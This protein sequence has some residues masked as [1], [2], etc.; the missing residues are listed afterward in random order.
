[1][2]LPAAMAA[3]TAGGAAGGAMAWPFSNEAVFPGT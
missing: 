3:C 2:R 1:M